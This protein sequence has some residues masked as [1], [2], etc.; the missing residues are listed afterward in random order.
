MRPL[1]VALLVIGALAGCGGDDGP[2]EEERAQLVDSL[3]F[4]AS[5]LGLSDEEVACTARTIEERLDGADLDEVAEQVRRVDEGE[6][7][8][9]ELPADVSDT[10]TQ[11]VA[12]CAGSS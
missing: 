4:L 7:A 2:G 1:I 12:S 3:G 8:L 5:D 9:D 6:V 11:S 10:L